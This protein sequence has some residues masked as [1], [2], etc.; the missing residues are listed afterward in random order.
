MTFKK[1][2]FLIETDKVQSEKR[3]KQKEPLKIER[4]LFL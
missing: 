3:F 2:Q 4:L 1:Y